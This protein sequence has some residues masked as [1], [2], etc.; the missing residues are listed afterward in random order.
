V[1]ITALILLTACTDR[2]REPSES[3]AASD[4]STVVASSGDERVVHVYNWF[5]YIDP[6]VLEK[7]TVETGIKVVYDT[8]ESNEVLET[9]LL[10]G[11]TGY[12]VVVPSNTYMER[13]IKAGALSKLDRSKLPNWKNLDPVIIERVS[14]NDP[15]N[16]YGVNYM[17]GTNGIGYNEAMV[18]AIMPDAPVDSWRLVF[19]PEYASR[20]KDCGIALLDSPTDVVPLVLIYLGKDP[21]SESDEDL[22]LAEK[23]LMS[24]RPYVRMI[25]SSAPTD[26]LANGELCISVNWNGLVLQAR[27]RA[28]EAGLDHVI[29][30]SIPKEGTISWFDMLAIP[31]DAPH[32]DTAHVFINF[33]QR[34]DIAAANSNFIRYANGNAAS[35]E[36]IDESVRL[37]PS[38]YPSADINSRI[39]V[40]TAESEDYTRKLMRSWTRF[41]AGG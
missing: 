18:E 23:R 35:R 16:Q 1:V 26:A 11:N 36:L 32:P 6:A 5:D 41:V 40:D 17:W 37:D 7:F 9:K 14:M 3:A 13:Q 19:E 34:P 31:K 29:K 28:L 38:I 39:L 33:M 30:Y 2:A 21:N 24:I 8:Y 12:D 22:K 15:G 27:D 10:T 20:F 25:H 4:R